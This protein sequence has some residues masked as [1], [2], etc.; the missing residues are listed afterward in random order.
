MKIPS[1]LF[2]SL[3][4]I[5]VFLLGIGLIASTQFSIPTLF[6]A[7][8]YLHIRM[9]EI[10]RES[11]PIKD[12][13]WARFS[14]FSS[15]FSDKDFLYHVALIPF[16]FFSDIFF[17]AKVASLFFAVLFLFIFFFIL[18]KYTISPLVPL[19]LLALFLSSYFPQIF[20]RPRPM[21]FVISLTLIALYFLI[22][23]KLWG[24]FV[25]TLI[26]SLSHVSGPFILLYAFT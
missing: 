1:K 22:E 17:G 12:F 23:K 15:Y 5:L 19:T 21:I 8:G 25:I 24:V 14:V 3:S 10:I 7:D 16:T 4:L 9:A 13:H 26:Y 2:Y 20:F 6:G 18:Q 11:G